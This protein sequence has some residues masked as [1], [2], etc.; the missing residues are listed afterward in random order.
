[1]TTDDSDDGIGRRTYIKGVSATGAIAGVGGLSAMSTPAQAQAEPGEGETTVAEFCGLFSPGAQAQQCLACVEAECE[2][3]EE[4]TALDPLFTGLTGMCFTP[5]EIPD[6]ADYVTLKAGQNCYLAPVDDNTTFCLPPGAPDISNATFYRCGGDGE[7]M[8]MDFTVTCEE[9]TVTTEN[10]DDGETLTATV[11]FIDQ[12][13]TELEETFEAEVDD[14]ETTFDLP[15]DLNPTS[16]VVSFD[17]TVL[18]EQDVVAEDAPCFDEPP[19]PPEPDDPRIE[20]LDVTCE[21]I[22]IETDDIDEGET[23]MVTVGFVGDITTTYNV[24]VDDGVGTIALPGDLDPSSIEI[25][26]EG[27]TLFEG[28]IQASDAPCA[29]VPPEPPEMPE[30]PEPDDKK[31]LKKRMKEHKAKYEKYKKKY[32]KHE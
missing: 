24:P 22:T 18:D 26:F 25:D 6:D 10:I 5:D 8:L 13:S 21:E 3:D 32:E 19:E 20:S 16:F 7:P 11:T 17:G 28:N 31:E 29:E 4:I 14:D 15:G 2:D 30:P 12:S 9:L 27:E 1:M 23:L